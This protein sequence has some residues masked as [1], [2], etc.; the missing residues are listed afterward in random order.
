M[1]SRPGDYGSSLDGALGPGLNVEVVAVRQLGVRRPPEENVGHLGYA[2]LG[3][4][5]RHVPA[6]GEGGGLLA[7]PPRGRLQASLDNQWF[8]NLRFQLVS[9]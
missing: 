9:Y 3:V 2:E 1:S 8:K 4:Q 7:E 5:L 6:A